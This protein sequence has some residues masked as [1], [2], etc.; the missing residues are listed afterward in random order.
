[1]SR[2][3]LALASSLAAPVSTTVPAGMRMVSPG[4]AAS[5]SVRNC[6]GAP[7]SPKSVTVWTAAR[8][9]AGAMKSVIARIARIARSRLG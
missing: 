9:G 6:P 1:M 5:M 7:L 2:S 4:A 8:A 3:P